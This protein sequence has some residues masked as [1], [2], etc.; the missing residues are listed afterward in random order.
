MDRIIQDIRNTS[1]LDP[2]KFERI[3]YTE[4]KNLRNIQRDFKLGYH[5]MKLHEDDEVSVD[6]LVHTLLEKEDTVILHYDKSD[7]LFQLIIMT[8]F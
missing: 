6:I 4:K 8:P 1:N 2:E 3:H 5:T 7:S